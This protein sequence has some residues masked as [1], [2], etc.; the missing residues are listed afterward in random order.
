MQGDIWIIS[1]PEGCDKSMALVLRF[2]KPSSIAVGISEHGASS[3][4]SN[5]LLRGLKVLLADDD[6]INRAVTRKLLEKL[7]CVVSAVG[8]GYEC[9][10]ALGPAVSSFRIVLLDLHMPDLDGFEVTSRIRKFRSRSWPLI[11]A[12]TSSDDDEIW[13]RCY[14]VGMS[15]VIRKPVQ[16]QGIE[17]ELQRV[18]MQANRVVS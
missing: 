11:I 2:Q 8:S 3:D 7:G 13:N 9:L 16:M 14:Q 5:S 4:R 12:L 15:G 17:D 10:S 6:D 1:N 18:L